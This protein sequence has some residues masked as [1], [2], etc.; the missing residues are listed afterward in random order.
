M[1]KAPKIVKAETPEASIDK[2]ISSMA[3][4]GKTLREDAQKCLLMIMDHYTSM[5]DH[6]DGTKRPNGDISRLATFSAVV[7][8]NHGNS[9]LKALNIWIALAIPSLKWDEEKAKFV[10]IKGTQPSI[11][12]TIEY[13]VG[14]E[15]VSGDPRVTH[16]LVMEP[17]VDPKPYS[18]IDSYKALLK[19]AEAAYEKKL[20]DTGTADLLLR[21]Q[22]DA[23]KALHVEAIKAEALEAEAKVELKAA[24]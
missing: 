5:V 15:T 7:R 18:F 23:V 19:N 22:I 17:K 1:A 14:K 13:K 12:K 8:D 20:K 2:L 16:F 11:N 24:E 3:K 9:G 21:R 6:G 4:R 10:H